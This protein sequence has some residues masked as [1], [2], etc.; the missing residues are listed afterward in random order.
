VAVGELLVSAARAELDASVVRQLHH[1]L[2]HIVRL[3][4]DFVLHLRLVG[5]EGVYGGDT[6][7]W[8]IEAVEEFIR[9]TRSDLG[10]ARLTD[11][12]K[13]APHLVRTGLCVN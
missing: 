6:L 13:V 9:D 2:E 4:Q 11:Q 8:G 12:S 3:R 5:D 1:T 10:A 7:D